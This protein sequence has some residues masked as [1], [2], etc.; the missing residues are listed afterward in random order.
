[1]HTYVGGGCTGLVQKKSTNG[2]NIRIKE[3]QIEKNK[4]NY[5]REGGLFFLSVSSLLPPRCKSMK[6]VGVDGQ[7]PIQSIFREKKIY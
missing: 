5:R 2:K 6:V 1:M 3:G 4:N 7:W